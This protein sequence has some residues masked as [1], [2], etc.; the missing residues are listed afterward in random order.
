[1]D[2]SCLHCVGICR[3]WSKSND[4]HADVFNFSG[5]ES[6][7]G[8]ETVAADSEDGGGVRREEKMLMLFNSFPHCHW[9][10]DLRRR[11]DRC[12]VMNPALGETRRCLFLTCSQSVPLSFFSLSFSLLFLSHT[13]THL[14]FHP[15]RHQS[16][17][18]GFTLF[19]DADIFSRTSA[20]IYPCKWFH[21]CPQ[22][23]RCH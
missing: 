4:R 15:Y 16:W 2:F 14:S 13:C 21:F 22:V 5:L 20:G 23:L 17:I 18:K 3:W 1:M 19:T 6:E 12:M 8:G 11:S 7:K 10:Q 9:Q